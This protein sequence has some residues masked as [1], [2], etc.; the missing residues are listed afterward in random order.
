MMGL[1]H[2]TALQGR[3]RWDG[4]D[5]LASREDSGAL[6]P[7]LFDMSSCSP[8]LLPHLVAGPCPVAV[9]G[10]E[11]T[12]V[13]RGMNARTTTR[14]TEKVEWSRRVECLPCEFY[15]S[16]ANRTTWQKAR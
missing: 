7:D 3:T 8:V 6:G 15:P 4:V 12:F 13:E 14:R 10:L 11:E 5:R 16:C 2:P 1:V 9:V